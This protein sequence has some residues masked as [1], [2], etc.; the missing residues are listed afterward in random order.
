MQVSPFE[1]LTVLTLMKPFWCECVKLPRRPHSATAMHRLMPNH[2]AW[3]HSFAPGT[4]TFSWDHY[5]TLFWWSLF[6]SFTESCRVVIGLPPILPLR[7]GRNVRLKSWVSYAVMSST[8]C[9]PAILCFIMQK[10]GQKTCIYLHI[11]QL[12]FS[13]L[14]ATGNLSSLLVDGQ[15]PLRINQNNCF[16]FI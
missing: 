15:N 9:W 6:K 10:L 4:K 1:K 3:M 8:L 11:Q 12:F 5:S 13:Q 7:W 14:D 16:P 2:S